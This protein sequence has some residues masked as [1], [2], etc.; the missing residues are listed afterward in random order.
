MIDYGSQGVVPSE[1][2][3]NSGTK[4]VVFIAKP[5]GYFEPREIKVGDQFDGRYVVLAGLKPGE[6]IVASGN[7]LSDSESRL[8]GAMQGMAGMSGAPA[9]KK[10]KF[11]TIETLENP[12]VM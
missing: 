7:F 8:G 5:G 2:V 12:E 1:A 4:Q 9:A 6:K 11:H 10:S 3:L